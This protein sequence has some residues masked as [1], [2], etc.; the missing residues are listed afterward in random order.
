MKTN[1]QSGY[2]CLNVKRKL[3]IVSKGALTRIKSVL[4]NW[5][6][7]VIKYTIKWSQA[8]QCKRGK[9][10]RTRS[11]IEVKQCTWLHQNGLHQHNPSTTPVNRER[12]SSRDN[13][14]DTVHTVA[15]K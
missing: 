14:Q 8:Y 9:K 1:S 5:K 6:G 10:S 15:M 13:Y 7:E 4:I 11:N 12:R 2:K 3:N